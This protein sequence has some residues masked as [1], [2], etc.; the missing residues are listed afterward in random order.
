MASLTDVYEGHVR[1]VTTPRRRYAGASGF[2]AGTVM[3]VVGILVATTGL[4]EAAGLSVV[5]A[6][7]VAGVL[8]GLGLPLAFLGV[9]A[10]LPSGATARAA[11]VIGASV[12]AFGV[13]LFGVA[14]PDQW[15]GAGD[16]LAVVTVGVYFAG[17]VTTLS[18]LF[19]GL[20]TFKTRNDPGGTARMAITEEGGVRVIRDAGGSTP[21]SSAGTVGLFGAGPDGDV[22]TQTNRDSPRP[23][24]EAEDDAEILGGPGTTDRSH[25]AQQAT[26]DGGSAVEDDGF[27]GAEVLNTAPERGRPDVYCGNCAHFE[28]VKVEE[29]ITPY[30]GLHD[31]L[32]ENMDACTEWTETK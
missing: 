17:G 32:M 6:R 3:V 14:Y 5:A 7:R 22:R 4:G 8:A 16:P 11:A 13:A 18:C 1:T 28:Y 30:C 23:R 21:S 19:A 10:V 29:T 2:A 31:E 20:A 26:A 9:F 15:F 12:S 24:D 27:T 25:P